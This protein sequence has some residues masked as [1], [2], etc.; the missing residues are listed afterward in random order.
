MQVGAFFEVYGIKHAYHGIHSA[1]PIQAF[2]EICN[3]NIADKKITLGKN[4]LEAPYIPFPVIGETATETHIA[5]LTA[6]WLKEMPESTIVMAGTRDYQLDKYAQKITE[7]G[8]TAIV[9]VQEKTDK[10]FIRRL[11]D[12]YSP[13]TYIA[14]DSDSTSK[15]SNNI[16]C[17]WLNKIKPS[18]LNKNMDPIARDVLICGISTVNIMT[19]ES[20][21]FEYQTAFLMNPT[22]FDELERHVS[23]FSPSEIIIISELNIDPHEKNGTTSEQDTLKTIVKYLGIPSNTAIH[24]IFIGTN[25]PKNE[26]AVNCTN[27]TYINDSLNQYHGADAFNGCREF[28]MNII[29]TQS[30]CYLLHFIQ[31]H[32]KEFGSSEAIAAFCKRGD[33]SL[34]G[35]SSRFWA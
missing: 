16:T 22:T 24:S 9:Y 34:N 33:M 1:T 4:K 13:G 25:H 32:N 26:K 30:Y 15:L 12:I 28:Q 31:E 17:I 11:H 10:G 35:T 5:K 20:Y 29:A 3:L 7:A 23:S 2:S 14:Y 18:A 8:F 27:Q 21:L 19:G 6:Q